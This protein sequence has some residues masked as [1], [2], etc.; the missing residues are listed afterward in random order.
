MQLSLLTLLELFVNLVCRRGGQMEDGEDGPDRDLVERATFGVWRCVI[1]ELFMT[2]SDLFRFCWPAFPGSQDWLRQ[3]RA[4]EKALV[5]LLH[6]AV[7]GGQE[8][9]AMVGVL[10]AR[11]RLISWE[12]SAEISR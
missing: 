9:G 11:D 4:S 6:A 3:C 2:F 1:S 10:A 5:V 12:D 7:E 8:Y